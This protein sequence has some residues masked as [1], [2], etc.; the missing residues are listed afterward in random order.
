MM[1]KAKTVKFD[2]PAV[3]D[4]K[5]G[6]YEGGLDKHA[7]DVDE[8]A[9]RIVDAAEEYNT[10]VILDALELSM[11]GAVTLMGEEE[12][13]LFE[14]MMEAF[15]RRLAA[16]TILRTIMGGKLDIMKALRRGGRGDDKK[17]SLDELLKDMEA[18]AGGKPDPLEDATERTKKHVK[19]FEGFEGK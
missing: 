9:M 6:T 13:H 7:K 17:Q 14:E 1:P 12:G 16:M 3:E 15:H 8:L 19:G 5:P 2:R 11:R 10:A 18:A 4:D